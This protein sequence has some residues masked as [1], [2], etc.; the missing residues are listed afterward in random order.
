MGDSHRVA[1]H[2]WLT[3]YRLGR[4]GLY[5]L[6]DLPGLSPV[7]AVTFEAHDF[8]ADRISTT[9]SRIDVFVDRRPVVLDLTE[10][11]DVRSD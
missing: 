10:S 7:T 5:V 6:V 1:R 2:R 11:G 3:D 9:T 8:S 4:A